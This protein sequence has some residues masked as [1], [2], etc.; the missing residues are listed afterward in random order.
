MA[1]RK[2][3][4]VEADGFRDNK[5]IEFARDKRAREKDNEGP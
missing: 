2:I 1:Q 5:S 4:S 3:E